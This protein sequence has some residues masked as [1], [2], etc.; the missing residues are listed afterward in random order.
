MSS[1]DYSSIPKFAGTEFS[2][3]KYWEPSA[4]NTKKLLSAAAS[5]N[6]IWK[7]GDSSIADKI[8]D[9]DVKDY[10]LMFGGEPKV[11]SDSFKSMIDGVFKVIHSGHLPCYFSTSMQSCDEQEMVCLQACANYATILHDQNMQATL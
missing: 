5:F 9:K 11:G 10:N 6:E 8:L 7:T 3:P 2:D 4:D 1:P